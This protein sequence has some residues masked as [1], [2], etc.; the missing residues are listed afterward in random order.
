M[1]ILVCDNSKIPYFQTALSGLTRAAAEMKVKSAMDGPDRHDVNGEHD[2]F[3]RA[4]AQKPAGILV[5][6]ADANLLTPDINS[7]VSQGIPVITFD[8]DALAE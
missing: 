1:Y 2:A 4:V 8:S 6:A 3:R 5:S 7:A